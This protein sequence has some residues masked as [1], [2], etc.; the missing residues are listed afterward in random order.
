MDGKL[1]GQGLGRES[2]AQLERRIIS[3]TSY[4]YFRDWKTIPLGSRTTAQATLSQTTFVVVDLETTGVSPKT[5]EILEIGAVKIQNGQVVDT[6]QTLVHPLGPIP[7]GI[8]RLT[9]IS[10]AMVADAP[11]LEEVFPAFMHFLGDAVMVAHNL[12]FDKSFIEAAAQQVLGVVLGNPSLCTLR[13]A[14]KLLPGVPRKGLDA[15][16]ERY[17]LTNSARHRAL[18]DAEVTAEIL[19]IFIEQLQTDYHVDTLDGLMAFEAMRAKDIQHGGLIPYHGLKRQEYPRCPGVYWMTN[20]AGEI[21]Y[22][23]KAKNLRN[24]LLTYFHKPETQ[25]RKVV[26]LMRQ[27][28]NIQFQT[29]GSELEALLTEA[30]LIK[31]HQPYFNRQ[32]KNYK[33]LPFI[34]VSLGQPY[35]RITVTQELDEESALYFGPFRGKGRLEQMLEDLNR[36]FKLRTCSDVTFRKYQFAPCMEYHLHQCSGPC[37]GLV[38]RDTYG[39]AVQDLVDFLEGRASNVTQRLVE[40]RDQMAEQMQFEQASALQQQLLTLLKLQQHSSMLVRAV[41][42]NHCLILLPDTE[43]SRRKALIVL[44]GRLMATEPVSLSV[45]GL[46]RLMGSLEAWVRA[47]PPQPGLSPYIPNEAFEE[48]RLL[49]HWLNEREPDDGLVFNLNPF[50]PTRLLQKLTGKL[51]LKL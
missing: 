11:R 23:G 21:L 51:L 33:G 3:S 44:N 14:R 5:A 20:A 18:G 48:A 22:I 24:R 46:G 16:A 4:G 42:Q 26:E 10:P 27:V 28:E 47:H 49:A 29:L 32:I 40:R 36:I 43:P 8:V 37:A 19:K 30:Q 9:G 31:H 45:D 13:L 35:P 25:P 50:E 17:Q 38:D 2:S 7:S 12:P 6:F 34:K 15:L 39:E 41:H 1:L